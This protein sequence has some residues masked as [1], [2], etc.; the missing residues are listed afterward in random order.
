M[1]CSKCGNEVEEGTAFCPKCGTELGDS[2]VKSDTSKSKFAST[3]EKISL[4]KKVKSW[5]LKKKIVVGAGAVLLFILLVSMCS[6]GS[7]GGKHTVKYLRSMNTEAARNWADFIEEY[8][9]D[10][11]TSTN[12]RILDQAVGDDNIELVKAIIKDKSNLDLNTDA[13]GVMSPLSRAVGSN[14]MEITKLLLEAGA[15]PYVYYGTG[16]NWL[17][18][19]YD[20]LADAISRRGEMF[21]F[22]LDYYKKHNLLDC[23]SHKCTVFVRDGGSINGNIVKRLFDEGFKPSQKDLG[24]IFERRIEFSS[25]ISDEEGN[26]FIKSLIRK[27]Q[28]D[29][30]YAQVYKDK[31]VW[32]NYKMAK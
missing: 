31:D 32:I 5:S 16:Y 28:N 14:K 3:T 29:E 17:P 22:I 26:E 15:K 23:S 27:Y 12:I 18:E 2:K 7:S 20:I 6:G 9:I 19:D 24:E 30:F 8:G 13:F 21:T 1:F 4:L 25:P 11:F 10:A